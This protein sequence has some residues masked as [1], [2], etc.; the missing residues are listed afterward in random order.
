MSAVNKILDILV[1]ELMTIEH[2]LAE[3]RTNTAVQGNPYI[4]ALSGKRDGIALA[5]KTIQGVTGKP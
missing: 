2:E 3:Q 4:C 1:N 5:I